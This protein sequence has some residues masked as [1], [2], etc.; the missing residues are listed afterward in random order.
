MTHA[1]YPHLFEPLTIR[2]VTLRN[3]IMQSAHAMAFN[4]RDGITT[5]RD[6][7]YHV[8]R[9]KGGIG[10]MITGNRLIHPTSIPLPAATPTATATRWWSVTAS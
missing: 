9:A 8:A 1:Q 2:N 4:T 7:H 5:D 10:L 3:R 6:I